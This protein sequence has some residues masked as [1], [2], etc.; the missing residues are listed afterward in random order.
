MQCKS[1]WIKASAKCIHVNVNVFSQRASE[2]N[3]GI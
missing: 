2:E 1:R 3:T